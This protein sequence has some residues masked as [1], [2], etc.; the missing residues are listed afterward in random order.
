MLSKAASQGTATC[1]GRKVSP[2]EPLVLLTLGDFQHRVAREERLN[3]AVG[4]CHHTI[5]TLRA[6][7]FAY[8]RDF[9]RCRLTIDRQ[10]EEIQDLF[11]TRVALETQL[12]ALQTARAA[13]QEKEL[14]E[15]IPCSPV[16]VQPLELPPAAIPTDP[17]LPPKKRARAA[18]T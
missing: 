11:G 8:R 7:L 14:G 6:K 3:R 9:D 2:P 5:D 18:S 4:D 13:Q 16:E 12:H 1:A 15:V 17:R 10:Q